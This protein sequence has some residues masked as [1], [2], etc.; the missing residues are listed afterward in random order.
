[1][2][3]R[4]ITPLRALGGTLTRSTTPITR[5]QQSTSQSLLRTTSAATT[6]SP[7]L[8]T[9][10]L[11]LPFSRIQV[12]HASHATQG[13]SNKH[14]RDPA[15]KRLGAKR[16]GGEYVVPGC[17]IFRQRGTK[18]FPGENCAMG[19]DHTIYA[20]EAGYVRYYLDPARHPDRQYIGVVFEKE[21]K[22]PT[23]RNAPT[24][25]KLNL[26]SVPRMVEE[27][28]VEEEGQSD[29]TVVI[30]EETGTVVGSVP[31]V[32]AGLGKQLRP[33]Y[34]W[35]EAN[36]QIGRAAEKAGIT[37]E[38]Y[39]RGNRWLAWRKRQARADRAAQMKSLKNKKKGSKKAKQ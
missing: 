26:V 14:S 4:L 19:R 24:R 27:T 17:I 5:F 13:A 20:S 36:W 3:P 38:R 30:G 33:G 29:L 37:A 18:W 6:P 10:T 28:A 32:D 34:M 15:G 12:R 22:L 25:R 39:N 31:A 8:S 23:P 21:G 2:L 9:N 1:M 35:R 7:I 11:L 16:T